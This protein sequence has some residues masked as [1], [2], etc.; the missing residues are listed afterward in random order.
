MTLRVVPMQFVSSAVAVGDGLGV[1]DA[2]GEGLAGGVV[3]GAVVAVGETEGDGE[4]EL[5]GDGEAFSVALG[6][7]AG[8]PSGSA[9]AHVPSGWR[10]MT[11]PGW[12]P[13]VSPAAAAYTAPPDS[14]ITPT[15]TS[16][17]AESRRVQKR[18]TGPVCATGPAS[19]LPT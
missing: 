1:G 10:T 5:D 7:G 18:R 8:P 17:H 11:W 9:Q 14:S 4:G 19:C 13:I 2:V 15:Q 16:A 3:G 6:L 12:Q